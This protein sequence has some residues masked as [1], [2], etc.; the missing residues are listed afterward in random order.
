M[1]QPFKN[2]NNSPPNADNSFNTIDS[3]NKNENFSN[4]YENCSNT[5]THNTNTYNTGTVNY[6][7]ADD[8]L[9]ILAWLSP[10]VPRV[11][12]RDIA[13]RRVGSIGEWLLE[14]EEFKRWHE[15]SREDGSYHQT[16]FCDGNPG[17]GKSY[18]T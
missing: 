7:T 9:E 14:T 6:I 10:L 5:N 16:L 2:K 15:G 13:S 11:R 8:R 4:N 3:F 12:H 18:I 17:A 1:L